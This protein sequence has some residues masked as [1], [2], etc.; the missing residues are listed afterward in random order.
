[1]A[2]KHFAPVWQHYERHE[3][4]GRSKHHRAICK[5]CNYELSGQPERMKTHLQRCTG[6]P[7]HIKDGFS[8]E[9]MAGQLSASGTDGGVGSAIGRNNFAI[10]T[11]AMNF[12]QS[13]DAASSRA[14][15]VRMSTTKAATPMKRR[16]SMEIGSGAEGLAG[17]PWA[18]MANA[19]AI[20]PTQI[21]VPPAFTPSYASSG[22]T[23][24]PPPPP[25]VLASSTSSL[26]FAQPPPPP[27]PPLQSASANGLNSSG[28]PAHNGAG[29]TGSS[30]SSGP[31]AA[32]ATGASQPGGGGG[33]SMHSPYH[34]YQS[35]PSPFSGV[36]ENVRGYYSRYTPI[37]KMQTSIGPTISPHPIIRD[38]ISKVPKPVRDRFYG[39]GTPLPTG[40]DG[41][42]VLDLG[43]GAGRDCYVAAKLVGPSGE[44]IGVDMTDEQL[45]VAREFV[46][47]Y[48]KVLGYQPHLRFVKGYIEFLSQLPEL[49]SGSIDVCISNNAVNLSPNKELV[50]RSVFDILKEG[51]EFQFSDIYADRRLPNHVRS[52]PVLMG[53]CLGGALYT[54][55]FKRLCQ[56]VGF[57]DARQVS[58]PAAVRIESPELRDL[59]GAT[60]F[61]SITFR[62]FKFSRPSSVLEPTREDYGQVAIYRGTIEGQRARTRFDNQWAFEANRPVLVDGNTAV[63]LGESWLRRHFEV[64]GDRSQHFG[65]FTADPPAVQYEPWETDHEYEEYV[66]GAS[67]MPFGALDASSVPGQEE[68]LVRRRGFLPFPTPYFLNGLQKQKQQQQQ[69]AGAHGAGDAG[70][71]VMSEQSSPMN[72][73]YTSPQ[74]RTFNSRINSSAGGGGGGGSSSSSQAPY[75]RTAALREH[76]ATFP[77]LSSFSISQS[78]V[79]SDGTTSGRPLSTTGAHQ[80]PPATAQPYQKY[81]RTSSPR[82]VMPV[83]RVSSS[84]KPHHPHATSSA[85]AGVSPTAGPVNSMPILSVVSPQLPLNS[86]QPAPP[87]SL[88]AKE[89]GTNASLSPTP[90]TRSIDSPPPGVDRGYAPEAPLV[91]LSTSSSSSSLAQSATRFETTRQRSSVSS[92]AATTTPARSPI[93][94]VMM[95]SP[96]R[97]HHHSPKPSVITA[98]SIN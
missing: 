22:A 64:R 84:F 8:A 2:P 76:P 13:E 15:A 35:E 25:Q 46:P 66:P 93:A 69:Q 27:P 97:H 44:V 53:E 18:P 11:S 88:L 91:A 17:L 49:Y 89:A 57:M 5:F 73:S 54:E 80:F 23:T 61:Y 87:P 68:M 40:I 94:S 83:H 36:Y 47:E 19:S 82:F 59:L 16:R 92:G 6:C 42:R 75:S 85:S 39:C 95:A 81:K 72:D 3:P 41:L 9:D 51:G 45:R 74:A 14:G 56:R 78:N 12:E 31:Q 55:D 58:P 21:A 26:T 33:S 77:R 71:Q 28:M 10:S 48:S 32:A 98:A 30:G 65:G 60:Q 29:V 62:L 96:S 38:A 37:T 52:H 24:F 43:C 70:S 86:P 90:I 50:L 79:R 4:T 20:A 1:M 7:N 34:V 67:G 63:M